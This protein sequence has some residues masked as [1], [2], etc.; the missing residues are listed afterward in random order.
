MTDTA[1]SDPRSAT[2]A[3]GRGSVVVDSV[4]MRFSRSKGRTSFEALRDVSLA[5]RPGEFMSLVGPS[6]CGK[7][8]LLK[9]IAGLQ[10]PSAGAVTVSGDRVLGPRRSVGIMFQ[11]PQLFPWRNVL[12]N[13]LLPVD[14]FGRSRR[15]YEGRAHELLA[16]VG[17]DDQVATAYPKEL[18]G[19][20]Q[21]RV[22]LCRV[23]IADPEIILMDEPFASV[24][25]FTRERLDSELLDV[26]SASGKTVVFVTHNIAEAVFLADRVVVM[27]ARPGRIVEEQRSPLG[28][29]RR[30]D[31]TRA[32][33]FVDLVHD[34]RVRLE[35]AS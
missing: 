17:L 2:T 30:F 12:S 24:D 16:L 14:V 7:S 3:D 35:E 26:W 4:G 11:A 28:R 8:T 20:M 34:I 22:A 18:S 19:G 9:I 13:V 31:D 5:I 25:E 15:D 32:A 23:L 1:S 21:Q 29:P 6:G 10:T 33:D 27:G